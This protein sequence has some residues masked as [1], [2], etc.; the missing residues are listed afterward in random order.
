MN[1]LSAMIFAII[2]FGM[3]MSVIFANTVVV[4]AQNGSTVTR[5]IAVTSVI[6]H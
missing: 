3:L 4:Y 1:K 6:D 2:I 5:G